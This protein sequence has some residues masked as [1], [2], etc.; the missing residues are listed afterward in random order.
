MTQEERNKIAIDCNN[1]IAAYDYYRLM[2]LAKSNEFAMYYI[3]TKLFESN[4]QIEHIKN[5]LK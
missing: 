4:E 1:A 2:A 3:I 5:I